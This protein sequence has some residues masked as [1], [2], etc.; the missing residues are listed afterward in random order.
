[1]LYKQKL[2]QT[3]ARNVNNWF[4]IHKEGKPRCTLTVANEVDSSKELVSLLATLEGNFNQIIRKT[5]QSR[6]CNWVF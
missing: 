5:T 2:I 4:V 3:K 1:M 6:L